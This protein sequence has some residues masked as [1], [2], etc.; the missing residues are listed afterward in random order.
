V[1][2]NQAPENIY[3]QSARFNGKPLDHCWIYHEALVQGG[4]LELDLGPQPNKK[5]GVGKTG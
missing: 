4:I 1:A 2:H 5:W 3:I